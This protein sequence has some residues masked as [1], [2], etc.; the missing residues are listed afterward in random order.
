MKKVALLSVAI[1][2]ILLFCNVLC[3]ATQAQQTAKLPIVG[4]LQNLPSQSP[5]YEGFRQGLRE[6]GWVDGQ[7]VRVEQ[8]SVTG[9]IARLSDVARE[10]VQLGVDVFYVAGHQGLS[11]AKAATTT[12]PIVVLACDPLDDLIASIARP[13]GSATGFSCITSELAGKR[14]EL[15]RE[16]A[17]DAS[18]VAVLYNPQDPNKLSEF[19]LVKEAARHFQIEA[20]PFELPEPAQFDAMFAEMVRTN[21]HSLMIL[22]DPVSIF[23]VK[24][25]AEHALANRLPAIYGFREFAELGGLVSYGANLREQ[26]RQAAGYVSK[27]LRGAKPAEL[28]VQEPTRFELVIN[29]K[30]A[31]ALGLAVPQSLLARADE[32]IE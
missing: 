8:R 23:H 2:S 7:N 15:L 11:A 28:P 10:L 26:H 29:L 1:V 14:L 9:E 27:I 31:K 5:A 21:M 19:Q 4:W 17:P 22:A 30:T 20:A 32:V 24:A 25:L 3:V 6:L 12:I 13:G 18:R 16:F